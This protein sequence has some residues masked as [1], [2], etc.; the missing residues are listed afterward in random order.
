MKLFNIS[1]NNLSTKITEPTL[2]LNGQT[3]VN[4][5]I[6]NLIDFN[7]DNFKITVDSMGSK[8]T[9]SNHKGPSNSEYIARINCKGNFK[10]GQYGT[11]YT[12]SETAQNVRIVTYGY[13]ICDNEK[14]D[15]GLY[16]D[17]LVT[18]KAPC[19]IYVKPCSHTKNIG[20]TYFIVFNENKADIVYVR[21]VNQYKLINNIQFSTNR[22][23][24]I[25]FSELKQPQEY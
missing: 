23:D 21:S 15:V 3:K 22:K 2:V 10:I 8:I 17:W 1:K 6:T 12:L 11:A 7:A 25:D 9:T 13:D 16:F 5:P 19:I 14:R 24:Y 20:D 18:V 4:I